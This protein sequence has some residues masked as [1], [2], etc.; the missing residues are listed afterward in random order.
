[1]EDPSLAKKTVGHLW[2]SHQNQEFN[3]YSFQYCDRLTSWGL[4]LQQLWSESL[5]KA[6]T[7]NNT[8]ASQVATFIPCRGASDQHSVLQQIMEGPEKKTVCFHQVESSQAGQLKMSQSHFSNSIMDDRSIGQLLSVQANATEQAVRERGVST[9]V[10]KTKD[11][12]ETSMG[13]LMMSWMLAIGALGELL[14]INAF[15]QPG[16]ESGKVITRR[17]LSQSD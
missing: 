13:Y 16:V 8:Q 1:M 2:S 6:T 9:M 3:F 5:A 12:N 10:L 11:L 4:W 14:D 7:R 17:V 15:D